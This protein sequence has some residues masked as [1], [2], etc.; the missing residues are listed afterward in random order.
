MTNIL[1]KLIIYHQRA[2][3]VNLELNS[4]A[5]VRQ[6]KEEIDRQFKFKANDSS[7]LFSGQNLDNRRAL[8]YYNL[9]DGD[10]LN[11]VTK[12]RAIQVLVK[13]QGSTFINNKIEHEAIREFKD[14]F[15]ESQPETRLLETSVQGHTCLMTIRCQI[16][17]TQLFIL[18][19]NV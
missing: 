1:M 9:Q 11:L 19:L 16:Y 5:A 6:V 8:A 18:Y 10:I 12:S 15:K 13:Y 17:Q 14:L 7:L 3:L 4:T 2:Y